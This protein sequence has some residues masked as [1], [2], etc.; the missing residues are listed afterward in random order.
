VAV[1]LGT[2]TK[3]DWLKEKADKAAK[4]K[5]L[6]DTVNA[7]KNNNSSSSNSSSS[8]SAIP[9][10]PAPPVSSPMQI[11]SSSSSKKAAAAGDSTTDADDDHLDDEDRAIM[12]ET[13]SKGYCYFRYS[14]LTAYYA[15]IYAV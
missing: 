7:A 11:D 6:Q 13:A 5:A 3:E 4:E 9:R 14:L 15:D 12:K 2:Q 8:S 10:A 1:G